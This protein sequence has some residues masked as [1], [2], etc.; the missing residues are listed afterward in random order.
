MGLIDEDEVRAFAEKVDALDE[1][2][3]YT[4]PRAKL[5]A[6]ALEYRRAQDAEDDAAVANSAAQLAR[7]YAELVDASIPP[8]LAAQ[9]LPA[10]AAALINRDGLTL[11]DEG[12]PHS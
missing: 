8:E 10:A 6:G 1:S 7:F 5:V 12:N 9:V 11:R 4:V 3:R 2:G